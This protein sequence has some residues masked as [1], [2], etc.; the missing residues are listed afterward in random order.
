VFEH[1][2]SEKSVRIEPVTTDRFAY[3]TQTH[4][5]V[6]E[7]ADGDREIVAEGKGVDDVIDAKLAAIDAM[8]RI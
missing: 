2:N 4:R 1:E 5:V 8:K 6:I 3:Y 7:T